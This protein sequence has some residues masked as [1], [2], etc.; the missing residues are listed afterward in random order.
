[1]RLLEAGDKTGEIPRLFN[2]HANSPIG[3]NKLMETLLH[4]KKPSA[5]KRVDISNEELF[6]TNTILKMTK[7]FFKTA[8][9]NIDD[10]ELKY[11]EEEL[12]ELIKQIRGE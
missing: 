5:I 2:L 10:T 9:I 12:I 4:S 11:S 8:G 6:N 7:I 3:V 1:M